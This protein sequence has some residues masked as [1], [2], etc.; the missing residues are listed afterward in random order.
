MKANHTQQVESVNDGVPTVSSII[1]T[2]DEAHRIVRVGAWE[3]TAWVGRGE[4]EEPRMRDVDLGARLG[5]TNPKDIRKLA[6]DHERAENINPFHVRATVARTGAAARTEDEMWFNEADALWLASQ[7]K[8]PVAVAITKEM[9][10]VY[11]AARKGLLPQQQA[12]TFD[13]E[14]FVTQ[15]APVFSQAAANAALAAVAPFVARLEVIERRVQ[16]GVPVRG[17]VSE[18]IASNIKSRLRT[19]GTK[20]VECGHEKKPRSARLK[21]EQRLRTAVRWTGRGC[22]W[23]LLPIYCEADALRELAA[24]EHEA[25]GICGALVAAKQRSFQFVDDA[26]KP[27]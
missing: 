13:V 25:N 20:L 12:Q 23:H 2:G 21:W 5:Y 14:A 17:T 15:L 8:T 6:R 3:L 26:K 19:I 4:A 10:R 24:M 7:S 9:I 11:I 1:G 27:N 18:A 16:D 22:H